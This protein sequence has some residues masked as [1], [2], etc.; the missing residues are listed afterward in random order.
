MVEHF[1]KSKLKIFV[2][3]NMLCLKEWNRPFLFQMFVR[4][5]K[6]NYISPASMIY[7]VGWSSLYCCYGTSSSCPTK[8]YKVNLVVILCH[9]RVLS[10]LL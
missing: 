9:P 1:A 10:H 4:F 2:E 8:T 7:L 5:E 6:C 3:Q